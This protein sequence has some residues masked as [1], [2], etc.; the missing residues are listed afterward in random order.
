MLTE[1]E[2]VRQIEGEPRRRWFHDDHF[3][4]IVWLGADEG[5]EMPTAPQETVIGFQLCYNKTESPRAL[6]WY[7]RSGY[8][9]CRVDDGESRPGKYKAAPILLQNGPFNKNSIADR[10][11][12]SSR[13]MDPEI[14]RFVH[15]K[16]AAYAP[17][18][19]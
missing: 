6:T 12:R 13:K 11:M 14:A 10:F 4:L 1:I 7:A 8:S 16:I 18:M 2:N 3:D 19:D 15:E 17:D 9:H 5:P